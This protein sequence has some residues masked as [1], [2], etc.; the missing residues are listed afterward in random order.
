MCMCEEVSSTSPY[1]ATLIGP[2]GQDKHLK[3]FFQEH[4][5]FP[6]KDFVAL[7]IPSNST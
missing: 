7:C 6:L 3:L 5:V 4:G 1:S 2:P